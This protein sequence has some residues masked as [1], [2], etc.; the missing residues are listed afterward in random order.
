MFIKYKSEET[1]V[2]KR[3]S[4]TKSMTIAYISFL[5]PSTQICLYKQKAFF[6]IFYLQLKC[7]LYSVNSLLLLIIL[8]MIFGKKQMPNAERKSDTEDGEA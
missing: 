1:R 7:M 5:D 3:L 2:K 4:I 6:N 8:Q